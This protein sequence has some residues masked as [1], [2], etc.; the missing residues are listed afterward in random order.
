MAFH[1]AA[2]PALFTTRR[3]DTRVPKLYCTITLFDELELQTDGGETRLGWEKT[4]QMTL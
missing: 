3:I 4:G 1:Y 2:V